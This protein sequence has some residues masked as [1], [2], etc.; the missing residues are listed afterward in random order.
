MT[1]VKEQAMELLQSIPDDKIIHIIDILR[2]LKGLSDNNDINVHDS[3]QSARGIFNKYAN[4]DLI[5]MEK[6][7]WGKAVSEKYD[8]N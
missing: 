4:T 3:A 7:A 8:N 6:D 2:G 1:K 5:S